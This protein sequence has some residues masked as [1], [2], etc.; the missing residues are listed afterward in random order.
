MTLA[1]L[2]LYSKQRH[3]NARAKH[4][5]GNTNSVVVRQMK[6]AAQAPKPSEDWSDVC[7]WHKNQR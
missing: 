4:G 5:T 7:S 2:N 1:Q 3:R 6:V